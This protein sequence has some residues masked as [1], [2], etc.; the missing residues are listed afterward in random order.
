MCKKLKTNDPE[1]RVF[2]SYNGNDLVASDV[3]ERITNVCRKA[4]G[5]KT[6]KFSNTHFRMSSTSQVRLREAEVEGTSKAANHQM[7]LQHSDE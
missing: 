1:Q 2:V 7:L 5:E 4:G 3:N 6:K